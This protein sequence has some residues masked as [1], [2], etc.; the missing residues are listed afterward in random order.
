MLASML[1][2]LRTGCKMDDTGFV[3]VLIKPMLC[4]QRVPSGEALFV[5][6][7]RAGPHGVLP[8]GPKPLCAM[9]QEQ[10][11]LQRHCHDGT[12][13]LAA[14]CMIRAKAGGY[15]MW[16]GQAEFACTADANFLCLPPM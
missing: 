12:F 15:A 4:G 2:P 3:A 9:L 11:L 13:L 16:C 14:L 8:A 1:L 6:T 7:H 10:H 5:P